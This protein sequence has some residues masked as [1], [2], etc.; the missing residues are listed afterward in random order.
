VSDGSIA[1]AEV[2]TVGDGSVHQGFNLTHRS[3][4]FGMNQL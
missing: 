3:G 1:A 2:A 4:S